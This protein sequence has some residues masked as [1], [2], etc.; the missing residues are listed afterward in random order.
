MTLCAFAVPGSSDCGAEARAPLRAKGPEKVLGPRNRGVRR[1]ILGA[2]RVPVNPVFMRVSG[3]MAR[4]GFEPGTPRFSG[5]LATETR[6]N[7]A[8]KWSICRCFAHVPGRPPAPRR[9]QDTAGC[10]RLPAGFGQRLGVVVQKPASPGGAMARGGLEP[11]T[12]RF[13]G[14]RPC[15]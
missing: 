6:D 14:V 1:T 10:P 12:P 15:R 4:P 5:A 3:R 7:V 13:S 9:G 11:P 2:P 8:E